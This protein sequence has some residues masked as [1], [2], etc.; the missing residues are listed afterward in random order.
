MPTATTPPKHK[1]P[2]YRLRECGGHAIDLPPQRLV[3]HT[4]DRAFEVIWPRPP[5]TAKVW[6]KKFRW[7]AM[8][9]RA[10]RKDLP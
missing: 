8:P 1:T 4:P 3:M 10:D 6:R 2:N 9:L 7:E 5:I